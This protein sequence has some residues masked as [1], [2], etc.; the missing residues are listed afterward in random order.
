M[1]QSALPR[2]VLSC[3][4]SGI[5][6]ENGLLPTHFSESQWKE[7]GEKMNEFIALYKRDAMKLLQFLYIWYN[8]RGIDYENIPWTII[9]GDERM[10][11]QQFDQMHSTWASLERDVIEFTRLNQKMLEQQKSKKP[12][13][14]R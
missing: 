3:Y 10:S 6:K 1:K 14:D 12:E 5:A 9:S 2:K 13:Q 11:K 4:V 7:M 8:Y